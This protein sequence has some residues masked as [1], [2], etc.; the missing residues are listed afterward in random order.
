MGASPFAL[1]RRMMEDMDRMFEELGS[2]RGG[3]QLGQLG[4]APSLG[5]W[6]PQ[7]D[8]VER[9]GKLFVRADLPGLRKDDVRVEV[10][11]E[12][13]V[14]EGERRSE[15]EEEREGMFRSERSYGSFRRIIPLPEGVEA[16]SAEARF[17]NGVLEV[18]FRLPQEQA[19]RR[20]IE[21]QEGKAPKTMH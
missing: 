1:M 9:G 8:V 12:G 13:L 14:L 10:T 18:T 5:F 20:R 6:E 17:D 7:V 15:L 3:G 16:E 21:I 11:D 2:S 19:R 4:R